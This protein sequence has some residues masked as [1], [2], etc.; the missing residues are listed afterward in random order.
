MTAIVERNKTAE[1]RIF[2]CLAAIAQHFIHHHL[3][4]S[5][6]FFFFVHFFMIHAKTVYLEAHHQHKEKISIRI[7]E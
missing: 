6:V 4:F 2:F 5:N 1:K 7:N 3:H